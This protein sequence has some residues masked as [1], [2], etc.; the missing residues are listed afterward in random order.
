ML[1]RLALLTNIQLT[2]MQAINFS[3]R[4][5]SGSVSRNVHPCPPDLRLCC[6]LQVS[7]G[8][9]GRSSAIF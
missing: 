6:V 9:F 8:R 3:L 2:A 5:A 4:L 7:A 1:L